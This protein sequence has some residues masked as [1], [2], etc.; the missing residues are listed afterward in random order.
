MQISVQLRCF[1]F[2][3]VASSVFSII[4][5]NSSFTQIIHP[6]RWLITFSRA[7]PHVAS[8]ARFSSCCSESHILTFSLCLL[9][10]WSPAVMF[11][12]AMLTRAHAGLC[13]NHSPL[14][15]QSCLTWSW[16][17]LSRLNNQERLTEPLFWGRQTSHSAS[18]TDWLSHWQIDL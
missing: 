18:L 15:H 6:W 13:L 17:S 1:F 4:C 10:V 3:N 12:W 16:S 2:Q 11:P 14:I 5:T 8:K 9:W 7:S